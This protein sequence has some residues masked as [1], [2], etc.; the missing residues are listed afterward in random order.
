MKLARHDSWQNCHLL[1][2]TLASAP[3]YHGLKSLRHYAEENYCVILSTASRLVL[4]STERS[5]RAKIVWLC[6]CVCLGEGLVVHK[7]S[8]KGGIYILRNKEEGFIY[9]KMIVFQSQLIK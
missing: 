6:V 4:I 9:M 3:S 2:N 1:A 8:E 7:N 5:K